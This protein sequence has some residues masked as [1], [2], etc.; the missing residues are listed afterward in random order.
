MT[1]RSPDLFYSRRDPSVLRNRELIEG[2]EAVITV[3]QFCRRRLESLLDL[4]TC[5]RVIHSA[6]DTAFFRLAPVWCRGDGILFVGRLSEEKGVG[7]LIAA[8]ALLRDRGVEL[9]T[10][11]VGRGP[12]ESRLRALKR[13]FGLRTVEFRGPLDRVGVR[14]ELEA[15]AIFVLPAVVASDG[16]RDAL[17]NVLKEAMAMEL[18]VVTSDICG[19]EELVQHELSGLLISESSPENLADA[20]HLLIERPSA[21]SE[22]GKRGRISILRDFDIN[23]EGEKLESVFQQVVRG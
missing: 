23:V 2:A 9:R 8:M 7:N 20:V 21:R 10:V 16:N 15:A 11:L 3:S 5:V 1:C 13:Q 14:A 12:Q 19:I 22:M 6:I 17:P 18:P 4:G